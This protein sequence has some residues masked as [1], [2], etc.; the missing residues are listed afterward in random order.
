MGCGK[1]LLFVMNCFLQPNMIV[2][3]VSTLSYI[4]IEQAKVFTDRGG[5]SARARD[6]RGATLAAAAPHAYARG[7]DDGE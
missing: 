1:T 4:E 7:R 5:L 2:W 6:D 3:I